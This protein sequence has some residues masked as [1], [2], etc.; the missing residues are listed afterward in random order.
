VLERTL[1]TSGQLAIRIWVVIT[2]ALV[3]LAA[4]LRLDLLLGGFV[5]GIATHLALAEREVERLESKLKAVGYGFFIPFF[6]V[7]T[8]VKFDVD[9]LFGSA[10]SLLKLPLFVL[11]FLVVRGAPA[12]L[13]YRQVL[14]RRDRVALAV[15]SATELP[16][17]VAITTLAV[18]AGHMRSSTAVALVGAA[19][20]STLAFPIIGL[21]LRG[22]GIAG[23]EPTVPGVPAVADG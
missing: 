23:N 8:G 4:S 15:L 12:M 20:I 14:D 16:L 13:L 22:A 3:A 21:R 9:A 10:A 19:I 5:A 2:F 1:E 18:D 17:V 11:L 7:V 6:F